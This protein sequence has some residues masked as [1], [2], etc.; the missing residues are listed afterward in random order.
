MKASLIVSILLLFLEAASAQY[1]GWQH[2]GS[3]FILT[4]P[5][6]A[7]LPDTA[8]EKD[9]PL[10]VRLHRDCFDFR[11][12][13]PGGQD[14][15]FATSAGVPLAYQ[16]DAWDPAN[17]MAA[18]WV[19]IPLI[20]GNARQ[21]IRMFWGKPDA[22]SESNGK[23]V[24][25]HANGYLSVWHMNDPV[26]DEVGTLNSTN[27][28]T[29]P[30]PGI[31]GQARHFAEGHGVF[32]GQEITNYPAGAAPHSSQ[33]WLRA[34]QPNTIAL[35]WGNEQPQGKVTMRV[36]SPPHMRM[37]C[38]FSGA[39]V[40]AGSPLP[41]SQW[42][43][44]VHTYRKGESRIYVNGRL[45]G[46]STSAGAPLAI[47]RPA[48]LW[49]GGWYDDYRFVGDIDEV[50]ISDGVRSPYWVRL[51]YENQKPLQ[52]LVGPLVPPGNTFSVSAEQLTVPEGGH[53]TL[54]A[55]AGGAEKIYWIIKSNGQETVVAVDQFRYTFDAGRVVGDQSLVLQF[56]AIYAGEVKTKD[57]PV[58]IKEAIPEPVFTLPA[59]ANWDGRETMEVVPRIANLDQMRAGGAEHLNYTWTVSDIAVIKE[60]APG[61]LILKRAQ[62]SGRLTLTLALDNGGAP[63]I[64]TATI[65][66][67]EPKQ[68]PWVP[69]V[70]ASDEKPV[71]NQFYARDDQDQGTLHYN[72]TLEESADVVFLKVYA[73]DN[74][75]ETQTRRVSPD[76]TYALT[77]K[78]KPGLVQYRVE[79]G[80]R[81]G[82]N[83]KVLQT[84]T[85]LVCGDAYLIDGQSNALATDTQE[86]APLYTSPWIR[87]YGSP[88]GD[89]QHDRLNLWCNPVW[90]IHK[91]EKAELGYWGME[92]AKRLVE[93]QKIPI[94]II[95]GAVG[96]TRMDQHQR[97]PDNPADLATIYGR[98]LWRV[99]QARLTHGIRGILWHQGES[100]Q[101]ADGPT[102][103][104]GWETYEQYFVEMSAG[105]KQDYPN[106]RHLYIYQIWPNACSM[107]GRPASDRLREIQRNLPR[108]YSYMSIM[109]T[110]GIKP[111]G[112][113]HYPLVGWAEFAR[114]IQ[115]LIER[116]NYGQVFTR[117]ITPPD[118]TRARY[119]SSRKDE[120]ALEFDQPVSWHAEL[121]SQFYLDG[122]AGKI[123]SGAASGPVLVLKLKEPSAAGKITYLKDRSWNENNLLYGEN[124]IAA[125]T[126]CDVPIATP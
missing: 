5:D 119:T 106:V 9:F 122:E 51:E 1:P 13:Q 96:G 101:G 94:L 70:P 28:G 8:S 2:S 111:P 17:G 72:G 98:M 81:T 54:T 45:E 42:V 120:I 64:G 53:V 61:R 76:K 118:L 26:Q 121:A 89:P 91:D 63:T 105:W 41:M 56:K 110:L 14:L 40:A 117:P 88:T 95:N 32:C 39:D 24:F 83:E 49:L 125:L 85:N 55:Q 33:A 112:G 60:I 65:Q 126:F 25:N 82:N 37:E 93:S 16:I 36:D 47:Q 7:N 15:R 90:K 29:T 74:L 71:D 46:V 21:E 34:D 99:Q 79:F 77:I 52:T 100:D 103:R 107:G 84:V 75:I 116:D 12:A 6:G 62:N 104:Y 27:V 66:V 44:V 31:I 80:S 3:L 20:K 124:G 48:R 18:I 67:R 57:I 10:L 92:L 38:Y 11:Q 102:G 43:H 73:G 69:R 109:S 59:P 68:D 113:C 78:L 23:A 30:T 123:T 115:P 86:E 19:H 97:N 4:T 50:R 114:L 108:L 87:S 58:T 35:A 22:A